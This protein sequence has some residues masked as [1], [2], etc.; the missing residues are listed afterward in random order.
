[1]GSKNYSD[2][3]ARPRKMSDIFSHFDTIHTRDRW[4]DPSQQLVPCSA[5]LRAIKIK[6]YKVA[7]ICFLK[8]FD[9]VGWVIGKVS[10]L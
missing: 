9:T 6:P 5:Q 7:L 2:V 8:C 10:D 1:M 4:T 3:A